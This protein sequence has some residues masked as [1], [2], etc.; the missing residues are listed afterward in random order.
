MIE[1]TEEHELFRDTVRKF[2]DKEI[3]P[4]AE[5]W[6]DAGRTPRSVWKRCGEMGFLGL[7][8]PEEVGGMGA[9]FRYNYIF[10]EEMGRC[11]SPGVATGIAVQ[12]DMATPALVEHGN[13]FLRETY[14]KP[15]ISGDMICSIAVTEPNCGSDVAGLQTRAV[16]DGDDYVINGRKTFITN[17]TQADFIVCL[18]RTSD[19]PGHHCFSL[20]VVPTKTRGFSVGK[21]LKKISHPSSD[22]TELVLQDVR[23]SKDHLIGEEG[24]GFIYQMRQFQYE[25]LA[26]IGNA[27]GMM[28][29]GYEITKEYCRQ[30]ETFGKPLIQRQVVQHKLAEMYAEITMIETLALRCVE[31]AVQKKDFSKLCTVLKLQGA[32]AKLNVLEQCVQLHG[33]YGLMQEYE[34]ARYYRD[35]KLTTI[36]GGA[37]EVMLEILAKMENI[38]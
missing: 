14:L 20:I 7:S 32:R 37:N 23:V 9:D 8:Y 36:G 21:V 16:R 4:F 29:R 19:K 25:R 15:A 6:E 35:S 26:A 5:Q 22:T 34:V 13:K 38:R 27:I 11:G 10:A 33:G 31:L 1:F 17:G 12:S 18:A 30:R 2:I 3:R 28:K 24:E